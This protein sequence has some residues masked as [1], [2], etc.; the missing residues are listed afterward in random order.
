MDGWL[1]MRIGLSGVI[2]G[3][4][5]MNLTL[6]KKLV[7]ID[8][9]RQWTHDTF[10]MFSATAVGV[11]LLL[12]Q[13]WPVAPG[14]LV[15]RA[16]ERARATLV[17]ARAESIAVATVAG[18]LTEEYIYWKI[19]EEVVTEWNGKIPSGATV[20]FPIPRQPE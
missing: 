14:D 5:I 1:V 18:A 13:W 8:N 16:E 4:T 20:T 17:E 15:A 2:V 7:L 3:L 19:A 6:A 10:R 12:I 11:A 9:R